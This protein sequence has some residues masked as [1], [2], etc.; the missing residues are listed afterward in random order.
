MIQKKTKT[1][2]LIFKVAR[3][4]EDKKAVDTE[5]L[6]LKNIADIADYVLITSGQTPPQLKAIARHIEESL[7]L[8]GIEPSHKEGTYGDKWFLLDYLDF[9]VHII[10][11]EAREFYN[12]E[13]LW[14]RAL[15]VP[16]S[17][18]T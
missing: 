8:E 5:I 4:A 12:L 14:S 6:D 16:N 9:V 15:F 1:K 18:W 2:E 3:L 7:S 17:E 13:E 10:D 11:H